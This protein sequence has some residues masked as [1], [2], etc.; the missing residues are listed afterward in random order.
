MKI[1]V[2]VCFYR[3]LALLEFIIGTKQQSEEMGTSW[4]TEAMEEMRFALQCYGSSKVRFK[5]F[6]KSLQILRVS[7][8]SRVPKVSIISIISTVSTLLIT[9]VQNEFE[10][11]KSYNITKDGFSESFLNVE[12]QFIPKKIF[13][14][15]N[16]EGRAN[17][18]RPNQP[19]WSEGLDWPALV[20][21]ALQRPR[22]KNFFRYKLLFY[23]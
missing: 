8:V 7:K 10:M 23:M 17:Q 2:N 11:L 3:F 20:I 14:S 16:L 4:L 18:C 13:A 9:F 5:Y 21:P 22:C 15:W 19:N 12:K 6:K 1:Y